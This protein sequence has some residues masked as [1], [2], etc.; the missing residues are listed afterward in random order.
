MKRTFNL[1]TYSD[2]LDRYRDRDDLI[3]ALDGFD[4]VELMHC[5]PDVRGVVPSEK[6]VGVHLFFFPYWYDFYTG[7]MAACVRSLGSSEAVCALY[8]TYSQVPPLPMSM[9]FL[10]F[11]SQKHS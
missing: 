9:Y 5:G 3:S 11:W 6:I 7:D 8:V 10:V 4:G 2:D 1:T